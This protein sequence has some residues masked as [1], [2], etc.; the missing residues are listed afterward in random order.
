M[1]DH[2]FECTIFRLLLSKE[3]QATFDLYFLW[4]HNGLLCSLT[5][6]MDQIVSILYS[7]TNVVGPVVSIV[8][9]SSTDV[10]IN[11]IHLP[12]SLNFQDHVHSPH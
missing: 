11:M 7:S 10:W 3:D 6:S 2:F 12:C 9:G 5:E 8:T 1:P 4:V